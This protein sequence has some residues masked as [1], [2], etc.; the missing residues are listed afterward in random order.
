MRVVWSSKGQ[1]RSCSNRKIHYRWRSHLYSGIIYWTI[2]YVYCC[3][4][5]SLHFVQDFL[6]IASRWPWKGNRSSDP[7][8]DVAGLVGF[9]FF[10]GGRGHGMRWDIPGW[11]VFHLWPL[12]LAGIQLSSIW[13]GPCYPGRHQNNAPISTTQRV[14]VVLAII[15]GRFVRIFRGFSVASEHSFSVRIIVKLWC[16]F[17]TCSWGRWLPFSL[18][19]RWEGTAQRT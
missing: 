12:F 2:K 15:R 11:L 14:W 6:L 18:W 10:W 8:L 19:H 16:L 7:S 3:W 5:N 17:R 1:C 4:V 9:L 13:N